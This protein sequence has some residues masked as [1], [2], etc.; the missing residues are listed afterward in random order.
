MHERKWQ[1]TRV[2]Y[3]A[4]DSESEE[5]SERTDSLFLRSEPSCLL[6]SVE[7]IAKFLLIFHEQAIQTAAMWFNAK[8]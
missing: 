1:H 3:S 8:I 6:K 7:K 4:S 5:M 2:L